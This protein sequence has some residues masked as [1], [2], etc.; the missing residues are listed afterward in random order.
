MQRAT[1]SKKKVHNK[2][3]L[4]HAPKIAIVYLF[5]RSVLAIDTLNVVI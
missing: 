4:Q 5:M 2:L 3:H 1:T